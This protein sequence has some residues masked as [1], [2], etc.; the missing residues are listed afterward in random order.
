MHEYAFIKRR[1]PVQGGWLNLDRPQPPPILE[2]DIS[3]GV[4]LGALKQS[5]FKRLALRAMVGA[6][7]KAG[8]GGQ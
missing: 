4:D 3:I 2:Q 1:R 6:G 5:Y 8:R 7:A